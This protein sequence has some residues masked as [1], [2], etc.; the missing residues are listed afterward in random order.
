MTNPIPSMNAL[1]D[2]I[3]DTV[4]S[5]IHRGHHTGGLRYFKL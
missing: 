1:V 5:A 2:S 4:E 3:I